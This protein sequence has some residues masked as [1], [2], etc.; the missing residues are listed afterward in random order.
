[1]LVPILLVVLSLVLLYFGAEW[2]VKG[3]ASS[4]LRL[5]LTPLV[6]GLTVVAYGTSAPEMLVSVKAALSGQGAIAIGN[7]VGS[8]IFNIAVIL[9]LAA[10]V[11]PLRV[12]WQ[13][14]RIDAPVML[15]TTLLFVWCFR[16]GVIS[17]GEAL[18]F[19]LGAATYTAANV[20]MARR[21]TAAAVEQEFADSVPVP[22]R[23]WGIDAGLIFGGLAVLVVGSR[24]LVDN[25]VVLARSFGVSEAVIGL[26]IVAA[27][28][29]MPELATSVVAALKKQA[30]I[31]LGNVIGSSTFNVLA[32]LGVAGLV[33][34]VE[35]AGISRVDLGMMVAVSALLWPMLWTGR[36]VNRWE[37]ALFLVG[38]GG[39][40]VY[41]WPK[42]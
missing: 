2:L 26:T 25:A 13:L 31:A 27:G 8:N 15:G 24:L 33:T 21:Q 10:V 6:V 9:G 39:Y 32:I 17:R 7:V 41:L 37:G 34:P 22:S 42:G 18:V 14:L 12:E 20:W 3:A 11:S 38:Y 28:T 35:G 30:D 1:M 40:L 36:C 4:A 29:S 23:H 5:G 16:D 19:V